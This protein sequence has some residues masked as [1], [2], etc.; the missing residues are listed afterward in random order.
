[1]K[2]ICLL[3]LVLILSACAVDMKAPQ[4]NYV[5]TGVYKDSID[6][7]YYNYMEAGK[8]IPVSKRG[9]VNV[10][11]GLANEGSEKVIQLGEH[12]E[13]YWEMNYEYRW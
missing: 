12:I 4:S 3:S 2:K 5:R 9:S 1:M 6:H 11:V 7:Q 10:S 8:N 13:D